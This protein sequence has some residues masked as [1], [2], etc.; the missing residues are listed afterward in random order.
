MWRLRDRF[1]FT[2]KGKG[3]GLL[4][5]KDSVEK[6]VAAGGK[7]GVKPGRPPKAGRPK[8]GRPKAGRPKVGRPKVG[9]PKAG[10]PKVGRPAGAK[11]VKKSPGRPPK[12]KV[13]G[14][15]SFR[16]EANLTEI[17]EFVA[18][19]QGGQTVQVMPDKSGYIL[20]LNQ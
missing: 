1:P 6:W 9:R 13:G 11:T 20:T 4:V 3:R 16:T 10:R 19:V 12:A 14:G 18:A 17:Q 7:A 5:A 2:S 15:L 8:V